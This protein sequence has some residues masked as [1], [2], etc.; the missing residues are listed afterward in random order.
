LLAAVVVKLTGNVWGQA[1]LMLLGN[2][3]LVAVTF[4]ILNG[5]MKNREDNPALKRIVTVER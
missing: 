2:V 3:S 5:T 4:V 1:G